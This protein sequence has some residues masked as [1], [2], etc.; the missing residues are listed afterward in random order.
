MA[1]RTLRILA[2]AALCALLS[3]PAAGKIYRWVDDEGG[4]HYSDNIEAVPPEYVYQLDEVSERLDELGGFQVVRTESAEAEAPAPSEEGGLFSGEGPGE[5]FQGMAA[6]LGAWILFIAVL[7]LPLFLVV[8]GAVLRLAC[9]IAGADPPTLGRACL[10][11]V[12]QSI[13]GSMAGGLVNTISLGGEQPGVVTALAMGA[14]S[15]VLSWIVGAAVLNAMQGYG[16]ARS[17]WVGVVHTGLVIVLV[18]VP[19]GMLLGVFWL[20][21]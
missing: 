9:R 5:A 18:L 17:L 12:A 8:G 16:M 21:A 19:I 14:G 11:L 10:I 3:A 1:G 13:A 2:L 4:T 7:A 6:A 20:L 15:S